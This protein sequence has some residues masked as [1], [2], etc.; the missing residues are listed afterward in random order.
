MFN[1]KKAL[2]QMLF[3]YDEAKPMAYERLGFMDLPIE[4]TDCFKNFLGSYLLLGWLCH[5]WPLDLHYRLY[6]SYA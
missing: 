3:M 6:P 1:Q 2:H 4:D 5:A